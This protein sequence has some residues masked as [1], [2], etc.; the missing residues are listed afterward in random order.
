MKEIKK[1]YEGNVRKNYLLFAIPLI[2]SALLSQSYSFVNSMIGE[3]IGSEAFSATAVTA[4]LVELLNSI[5]FGYL[6]GIGIYVSVLFGKGDYE[7][8]LNVIKLNFLLSASLA[9]IISL[10]CNLFCKQTC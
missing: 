7:K 1:L 6:T 9:I 10:V 8:M 4:E 3:F 2:L 5:F